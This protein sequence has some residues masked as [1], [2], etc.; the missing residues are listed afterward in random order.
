MNSYNFLFSEGVIPVSFR[1]SKGCYSW[2][3]PHTTIEWV[4]VTPFQGLRVGGDRGG[5]HLYIQ[6]CTQKIYHPHSCECIVLQHI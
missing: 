2:P 3:H 5:V 1:V 4:I 6:Y